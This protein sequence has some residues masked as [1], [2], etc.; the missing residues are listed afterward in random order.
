MYKRV[1]LCLFFLFLNYFTLDTGLFYSLDISWIWSTMLNH[2]AVDSPVSWVAHGRWPNIFTIFKTWAELEK[3][4]NPTLLFGLFTHY[5]IYCIF[6]EFLS[7]KKMKFMTLP[8]TLILQKHN[9]HTSKC[10]KYR[11][12]TF[13]TIK[14]V[15]WNIF[16]V[17]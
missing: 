14:R 7:Q 16:W 12:E 1:G 2:Q 6:P 15:F 10:W 5:D 9:E 4:W 13:L 3:S 8:I 17:R 11:N